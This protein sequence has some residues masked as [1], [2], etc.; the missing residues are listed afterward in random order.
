MGMTRKL[1][2]EIFLFLCVL[3]PVFF[4]QQ[5]SLNFQVKAEEGAPQV[6]ALGLVLGPRRRGKPVGL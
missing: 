6:S 3:S 4:V 1:I 2:L 5:T